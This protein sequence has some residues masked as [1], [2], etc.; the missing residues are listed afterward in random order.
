MS[1]F[2]DVAQ[3]GDLRGTVESGWKREIIELHQFFEKWLSGKAAATDAVFERFEGVIGEAF[4][5]IGPDGTV[6]DREPLIMSLRA[7]HGTRLGLRIWIEKP[8]IR[9][10][11]DQLRV[12]TYEEWQERD[13]KTA[14]R[15]S[16][17]VFGLDDKKINGHEWLHVHETWIDETRQPGARRVRTG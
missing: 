7:A 1:C 13:G 17:V 8:R 11:T 2:D 6:L 10:E 3:A 5:I 12:A 14:I 16:T 9:F 4:E 15:L